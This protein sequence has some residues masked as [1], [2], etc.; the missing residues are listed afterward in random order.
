M[1]RIDDGFSKVLLRNTLWESTND[2]IAIIN[3]DRI[4]TTR[5]DSD[6]KIFYMNMLGMNL[7]EWFDTLE[8]NEGNQN[9]ALAFDDLIASWALRGEK[10]SLKSR[11]V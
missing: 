7:K 8:N 1:V 11:F 9:T 5:N 3:S 2:G 10:I 6:K 4:V